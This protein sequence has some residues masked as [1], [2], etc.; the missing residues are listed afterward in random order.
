MIVLTAAETV[1]AALL[2]GTALGSAL[3]F[4]CGIAYERS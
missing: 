1:I 2:V 3:G 4:V